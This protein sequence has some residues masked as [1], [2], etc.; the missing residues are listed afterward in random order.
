MPVRKEIVADDGI[1]QAV[2]TSVELRRA[3]RAS[4]AEQNAITAILTNA[5]LAA[6]F[7]GSIGAA[8][9][10]WKGVP[11][12]PNATQL[13]KP[14]YAARILR[15]I[16]ELRKV[17]A[18]PEPGKLKPSLEF[19]IVFAMD[20]GA[21]L[22]EAQWRFGLGDA[23]RLGASELQHL[24]KIRPM[25][26]RVR[27]E[28]KRRGEEE[29][30]NAVRDYRSKHPTHSRRTMAKNLLP[31]HGRSKNRNPLDALARRIGRLRK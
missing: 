8:E 30:S 18:F 12:D 26:V 28:N 17:V 1:H 9:K 11:A 14:R 4:K 5:G 13:S 3:G 7:E 16:K 31:A 23:V 15:E 19:W 24:N 20:L 6:T 25:A 22:E 27:A 2:R 10:Y 21:R 29:L